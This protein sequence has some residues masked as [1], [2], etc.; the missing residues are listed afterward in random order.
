M[1]LFVLTVTV[2]SGVMFLL[3]IGLLMKGRFTGHC[4]GK[5]PANA[6]T[7]KCPSCKSAEPS[8]ETEP[9]CRYRH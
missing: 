3:S 7:P 1:A 5:D 9:T 8:E 2:V 6:Q 4:C